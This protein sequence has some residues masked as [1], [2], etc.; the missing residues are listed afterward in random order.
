MSRVLKWSNRKYPEPKFYAGSMGSGKS[1]R[2]YFTAAELR[3]RKR[4]FLIVSP[5]RDTR[6]DI[7]KI[8]TY[9][10]LSM[11]AWTCGTFQD[12]LDILQDETEVLL[13]DEVHF[14]EEPENHTQ[15]ETDK[16]WDDFLDELESRNIEVYLSGLVTSFKG[17]Y[18]PAYLSLA[19][20]CKTEHFHSTC[21]MEG[22]S[23]TAPYNARI[24]RDPNAPL[25]DAG[26]VDKYLTVCR[27]HWTVLSDSLLNIPQVK[28]DD[29]TIE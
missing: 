6:T 16:L 20:R 15:E 23:Q 26:G 4:N 10:G 11:P 12:V 21:Q 28:G 24:D 19:K 27:Y 8:T 17:E 18:M 2:L 13:I 7:N 1:T 5:K 14:W 25:I 29:S 9:D 3:A 22:C